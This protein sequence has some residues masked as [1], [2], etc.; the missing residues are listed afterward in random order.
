MYTT[1]PGLGLCPSDAQQMLDILEDFIAKL[2]PEDAESIEMI[3]LAQ[4][5]A[6][7]MISRPLVRTSVLSQLIL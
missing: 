3:Q 6:A 7:K 4:A 1:H 2:D 5:L